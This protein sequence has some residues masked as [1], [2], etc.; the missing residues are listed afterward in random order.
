MPSSTVDKLLKAAEKRVEDRDQL[1]EALR[2]QNSL[3]DE[4][5]DLLAAQVR[6]L[7][8]MGH[9]S[10]QTITRSAGG[11]PDQRNGGSAPSP[12]EGATKVGR[13]TKS[14]RRSR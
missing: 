12:L 1:I 6:Q 2:E 3:L 5:N 8:D 11:I 4:R 9:T 10:L 7:V 14:R 13:S